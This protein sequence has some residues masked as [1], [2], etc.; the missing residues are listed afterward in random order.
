MRVSK[1][2]NVTNQS[3]IN[4]HREN[5]TVSHIPEGR[6]RLPTFGLLDCWSFRLLSLCICGTSAV[7]NLGFVVFGICVVLYVCRLWIVVETNERSRW[8]T[9]QF[10][11]NKSQLVLAFV[12]PWSHL[13]SFRHTFWG[14]LENSDGCCIRFSKQNRCLW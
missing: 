1:L 7:C 9:C 4:H 10:P 5:V 12:M 2:R 11:P 8:E 3:F 6:D 14:H 13:P